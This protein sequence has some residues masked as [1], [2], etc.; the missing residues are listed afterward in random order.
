MAFSAKTLDFL[1]ENRLNNSREW[2]EEHKEDY[3]GLVLEPLQELVRALTPCMLEIDGDFVTEPRVDRTICRIRRDTRFSHDKSL[4]RD[5]M[6]VIFKRGRMH[7]TEMPGMYFEISEQGFEYGC[8]YYAASTS[9]MSAYRSLILS[10]DAAFERA[11]RAFERQTVY[12][13]TGDCY[14]R[15]RYTGQPER[16]R[17]WLER[18]QICFT[19]QSADFPLLFS[20]G[21]A[22]KLAEDFR[23]LAPIYQFLLRAAQVERQG[24]PH[25]P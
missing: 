22:D 23:L 24:Q 19:A 16:L 6:W 10:G 20:Q 2:F 13:L 4:Y 15:P 18:R 3:R 5:N 21:L 8:G 11:R 9:Y 12:E 14:K 1:F 17:A 7:G 25:T